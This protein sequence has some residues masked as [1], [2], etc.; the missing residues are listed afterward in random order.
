MMILGAQMNELEAWIN[1]VATD[2]DSQKTMERLGFSPEPEIEQ[3]EAPNGEVFDMLWY[4]VG[5]G[6][7]PPR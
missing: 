7:R 3:Y 4:K 5:V 6:T 1:T 2:A